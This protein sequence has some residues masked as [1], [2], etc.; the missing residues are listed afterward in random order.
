M[1]FPQAC[2]YFRKLLIPQMDS[3]QQHLRDLQGKAFAA[4]DSRDF[5]RAVDLYDQCLA[6]RLEEEDKL[7]QSTLLNQRAQA[8]LNLSRF[9]LAVDDSIAALAC[10]TEHDGEES[11]RNR[12]LAFLTAGQGFYGMRSFKKASEYVQAAEKIEPTEGSAG[13]LGCIQGRLAEETEGSYDFE[14]MLE[15]LIQNPMNRELDHA[16]FISNTNIGITP[17]C[18]RGLFATKD[19][20]M[21]DLVLCEKAFAVQFPA[22]ILS[23]QFPDLSS[24]VVQLLK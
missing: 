22:E 8:N 20:H 5:E 7:S 9:E 2:R 18:G 1:Y 14:K 16:S 24:K 19:F 6:I 13:M 4:A 21:G 17:N 10:L 12:R 11:I 23:D 15:E 3:E